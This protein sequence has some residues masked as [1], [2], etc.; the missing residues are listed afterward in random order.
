LQPQGA[1]PREVWLLHILCVLLPAVRAMTAAELLARL[2][3]RP[4]RPDAVS[5]MDPWAQHSRVLAQRAERAEF[6]RALLLDALE[7][8]LCEERQPLGRAEDVKEAIALWTALEC[9]VETLRSEP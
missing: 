3:E 9:I 1:T 7:A 6:D 4:Q 2:K 8:H 5:R